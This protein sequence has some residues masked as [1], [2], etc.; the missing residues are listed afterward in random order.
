MKA[1]IFN[2]YGTVDD[3]LFQEVPTPI[4]SFTQVL[5]KI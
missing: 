4:P 1:I 2:H 3:L 5:V